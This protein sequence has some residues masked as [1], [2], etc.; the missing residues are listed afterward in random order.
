MKIN[1]QAIIEAIKEVGR[2]AFF[3]ALAAVVMWVQE[4]A[5]SDPT[6]TQFLIYTTIGRFLDKLVHDSPEIK[7]KGIAPF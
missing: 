1:K 7:A 4:Q 5:G 2:L 3:A 6:T